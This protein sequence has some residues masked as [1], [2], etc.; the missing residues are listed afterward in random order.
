MQITVFGASGKVGRLVVAELLAQGH[1]VIAFVHNDVDFASDQ[2]LKLI[3]GD[4][5][6]S[7]DVSQAIQGSQLVISTLGSWHTKSKDILSSAMAVLVP[8]MEQQGIKRII[9]LTG[10]DAR[11]S[12]DNPNW[13]AKLL[14]PLF[15]IVAGKILLDGENHIKTLE[16]SSLDYT[17]VRAPVMRNFG[18]NT[19]FR[20]NHQPTNIWHT[21]QRQKVAA[22]ISSL[23]QDQSFNRSCPF[24]H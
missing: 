2:H 3:K 6:Q 7:S 5:H 23:V 17:V 1:Q 18:R 4:I 9:T 14:R 8:A 20:L 12:G 13:L 21:V 19:K 15:K 10:A 24:V 11:A 22:A 16:A